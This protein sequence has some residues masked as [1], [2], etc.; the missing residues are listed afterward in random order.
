MGFD[1]G[2]ITKITA[3]QPGAG[4]NV[5]VEFEIKGEF[6]G[7]MWTDS[8]V[9]L[10]AGNF[11][12]NRSLEV[13]KGNWHGGWTNYD[14]TTVQ[15]I[16]KIKDNAI[17]EII[18]NHATG[19]WKYIPYT[20]KT[21]P[22]FMS[23]HEDPALAERASSLVGMAESAMPGILSLTNDL[24]LVLTTANTAV[25]NLNSRIVE[26]ESLLEEIDGIAAG[27]RPASSNVALITANLTN[28]NGGLGQWLMP[29]N[30]NV[31][32]VMTLASVRQTLGQ[33]QGAITNVTTA[34]DGVNLAVENTDAN[35]GDLMDKVGLSL[36]N[37]AGIT[38]N[39][40]VQVNSNT[41]I[42]GE[43]SEAIRHTDDFVQGM[44]K[45]WLLRGT[46]KKIEK[47]KLKEL[48]RL[49]REAR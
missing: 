6:I 14:G 28:A 49:R 20:E 17:S 46:F 38:S 34:L 30:L 7:Y 5:Y 2:E 47:E 9:L 26:F 22:Y 11:L 31:E 15:A 48:E 21:K 36:I 4:Q 19:E 27:F 16:H 10:S 35:L 29:S 44:K 12:G 8:K 42:L 1:V 24:Q 23:I 32:T 13:L 43:V 37:L 41:N 18:T 25:S 33:A 45:F 40:N 39:L 3:E